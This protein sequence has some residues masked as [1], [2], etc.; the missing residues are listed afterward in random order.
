MNDLHA[1][2]SV[3]PFWKFSFVCTLIY[4]GISV[5]FSSCLVLSYG[6]CLLFVPFIRTNHFILTLFFSIFYFILTLCRFFFTSSKCFCTNSTVRYFYWCCELNW[7]SASNMQL[8][9]VHTHTRTKLRKKEIATKWWYFLFVLK[10]NSYK[11]FIAIVGDE[12]FFLFC[13]FLLQ[14]LCR[15][16]M[17]KHL[18]VLFSFKNTYVRNRFAR[19]FGDDAC[20]DLVVAHTHTHTGCNRKR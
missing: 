5:F 19:Q 2:E 7:V 20:K 1:K 17:F 18:F 9:L 11:D 14:R 12:F 13:W 3:A 8:A 16:L 10:D 15:C 4:S 6:N